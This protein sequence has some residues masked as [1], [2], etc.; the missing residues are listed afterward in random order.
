MYVSLDSSRSQIG[1]DVHNVAQYKS[2]YQVQNLR[3]IIFHSFKFAKLQLRLYLLFFFFIDS[4]PQLL[5][6]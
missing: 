3:K 4:I 1:Q 6:S 5:L 2:M